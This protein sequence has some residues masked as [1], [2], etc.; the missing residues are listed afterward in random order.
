MLKYDTFFRNISLFISGNKLLYFPVPICSLKNIISLNLCDNPKIK[1]L[2]KEICNLPALQDL[3]VDAE[4]F[5]YPN[6]GTQLY[7]L[8]INFLFYNFIPEKWC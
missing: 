6:K 3:S 2:P 5:T 1:I 8:L 4:R 7:I